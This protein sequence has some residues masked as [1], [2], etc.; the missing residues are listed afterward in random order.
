MTEEDTFKALKQTPYKELVHGWSVMYELNWKQLHDHNEIL[1]EFIRY[2]S[3]NGWEY[4][5]YL[6][7]RKLPKNRQ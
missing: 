5:D 7:A 4:E 3:K 2:L 6:I 1:S